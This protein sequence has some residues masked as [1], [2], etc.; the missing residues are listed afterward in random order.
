MADINKETP[1]YIDSELGNNVKGEDMARELKDKGYKNITITTGHEPDKFA[2][3]P[4]LKVIGK[5][6]PRF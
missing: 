1:I 2:D 3:L 6:P 4:W 5:E